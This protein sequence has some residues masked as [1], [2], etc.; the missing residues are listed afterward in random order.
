MFSLLDLDA[1]VAE[2][3][4][5][6]QR[7]ARAIHLRPGPVGH[8]S[9]ADPVF[10]P[11]WARVNEAGIAVVFHISESGYN[12]RYSVDWSE[13]PA[14]SSW[15]IS[16]FQWTCFYGDRPILETM[17]ALVLHNLFGRFPDLRVVSLENGSLW[18][19][20]LLKAMDKMKGMGRHGHWLGGR[21]E[22]RPSEIFREHVCGSARSTRRTSSGWSTSS[23]PSGWSSGRTIPTRKGLARPADFAELLGGLDERQVRRIMR[24]NTREL[25][26]LPG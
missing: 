7:G 26:G 21:V 15:N 23:A 24:D 11:F 10:D 25:L 6:M 19:P 22:G 20:Y 3:E 13:P 16:A 12:A 1:A 17:A 5:V 14:P 8:R 18:V 9:P 4:W 2:L